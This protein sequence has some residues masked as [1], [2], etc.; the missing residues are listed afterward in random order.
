MGRISLSRKLAGGPGGPGGPGGTQASTQARKQAR[1][2]ARMHA[3]THAHS[4]SHS[5]SPPLCTAGVWALSLERACRHKGLGGTNPIKILNFVTAGGS[6]FSIIKR[7]APSGYKS[8]HSPVSSGRIPHQKL[9][10]NWLQTG[11]KRLQTGPRVICF[12]RKVSSKRL[13]TGPHVI[14]FLTKVSPKQL[15]TG[16]QVIC[17][18]RKGISQAVTN[19]TPFARTYSHL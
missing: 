14:R 13:Q 9:V 4:L 15:Q 3:R 8:L 18:I 10:T 19:R 11:F 5:F 16:P 17:F 12:I 1:R 2:H 6:F 7:W